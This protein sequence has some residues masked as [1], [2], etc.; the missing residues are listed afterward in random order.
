MRT[1]KEQ[2]EKDFYQTLRRKLSAAG[3]VMTPEIE[4]TIKGVLKST[5]MVGAIAERDRTLKIL[6]DAG[7]EQTREIEGAIIREG[8]LGV[9]GYAD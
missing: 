5:A 4:G 9:L 3:L 8:V 2:I 7:R 6:S 1:R